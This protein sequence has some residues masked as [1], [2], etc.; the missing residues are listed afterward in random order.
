M[1]YS[2]RYEDRGLTLRLFPN[3]SAASQ[4]PD[5]AKAVEYACGWLAINRA[6]RYVDASGVLP[7]DWK[8]EPSLLRDDVIQPGRRIKDNDYRM[9]H[10]TLTIVELLPYGVRATDISGR[11]FNILKRRIHTDG[12]PR[13]NGFTLLPKELG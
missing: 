6:R 9:P 13:K 2:T 10:R 8:P 11:C 7:P 4:C 12:K 1:T 3:E 5:S